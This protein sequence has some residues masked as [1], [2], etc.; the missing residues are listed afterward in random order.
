MATQQRWSFSMKRFEGKTSRGSFK[1]KRSR[2]VA[3]LDWGIAVLSYRVGQHNGIT[4][5]D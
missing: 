5:L 2:S 3:T 4:A 1:G